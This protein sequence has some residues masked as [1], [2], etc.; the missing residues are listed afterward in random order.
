MPELKWRW[1][2]P[3]ILAVMAVVAAGM[4][5]VFRRR[6]WLGS[7]WVSP[8]MEPPGGR[9]EGGGR[10]PSTFADPAGRSGSTW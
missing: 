3:M 7:S 4:L 8:R 10:K 5:L 9:A 2:Y 6:G 1:G